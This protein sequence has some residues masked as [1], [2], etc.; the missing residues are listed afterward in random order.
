M[1]DRLRESLLREQ[2]ESKGVK[3]LS[4]NVDNPDDAIGLIKKIEKIIKNKKNNILT[5]AYHQGI[6]FRKFKTNN[7]FTYAVREF[8][9][10]KTTINLKIDIAKNFLIS[11]LK[12]EHLAFFFFI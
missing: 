2:I 3:E 4:M 7:R 11:V 8:K 9:I 5:L 12:C 6:I 10:S 1:L